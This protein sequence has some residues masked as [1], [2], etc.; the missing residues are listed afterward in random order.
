MT[1][2][3]KL[4]TT[5]QIKSLREA[6]GFK[7]D[8]DIS[9]D[10][11]KFAEYMTKFSEAQTLTQEEINSLKDEGS[12][13]DISEDEPDYWSS[14]MNGFELDIPEAR[15]G[16]VPYG[17]NEPFG[18]YTHKEE[19][20]KEQ[21]HRISTIVEIADRIGL[22]LTPV[23][24]MEVSKMNPDLYEEVLREHKNLQERSN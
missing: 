21:I 4:L 16:H 10:A 6:S 15:P 14:S 5:E 2:D 12:E 22:E 19:A 18:L 9:E 17:Y 7:L 3:Q 13:L 8:I 11:I 23:I 24:I 1:R 20:E